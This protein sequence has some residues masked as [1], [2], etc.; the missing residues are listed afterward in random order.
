M[1]ECFEKLQKYLRDNNVN[2]ECD[3]SS[4]IFSVN[5]KWG[6]WKHDHL[7]CDYLVEEFAKENHRE[8]TFKKTNLT[9][10]DG[11]DCYSAKHFYVFGEA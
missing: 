4:S 6:D 9:E 2:G 8:I 7:R 11:S 10:E 1:R 3:W 5:I